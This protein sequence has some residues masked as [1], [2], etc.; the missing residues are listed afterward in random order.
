MSENTTTLNTQSGIKPMKLTKEE[1]MLKSYNETFYSTLKGLSFVKDPLP[2][3]EKLMYHF[4]QNSGASVSST[5][6]QLESALQELLLKNKEV[7]CKI[8]ELNGEI[9]KLKNDINSVEDEYKDI[10]P[11]INILANA[12]KSFFVL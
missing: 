6:G 1:A 11:Q 7:K 2:I 10:M 12:N 4:E 5:I 3:N 9:S 8:K